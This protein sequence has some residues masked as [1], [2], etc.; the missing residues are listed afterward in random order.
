MAGWK[1]R[2]IKHKEKI[3]SLLDLWIFFEN[4]FT[5]QFEG[6]PID[7]G[8]KLNVQKTFRKRSGR[9]MN[10]LCT[11]NLRPVST[12]GGFIKFTEKLC[13]KELS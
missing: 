4:P 10:A 1:D 5:Y 8:R 11:F 12:E 2:K 7:T 6:G 13:K 3:T 9:L